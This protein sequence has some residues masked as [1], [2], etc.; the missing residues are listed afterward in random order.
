[1][2]DVGNSRLSVHRFDA[3]ETNNATMKTALVAI[4]KEKLVSTT[5]YDV[6]PVSQKLI[7]FDTTLAVKKALAALLQHGE[8]HLN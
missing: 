5:C 6:L 2:D 3:I 1:M 4:I 7:A 8:L